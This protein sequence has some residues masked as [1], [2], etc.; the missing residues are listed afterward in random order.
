VTIS[1]TF[2]INSTP[3]P[4]K[5]LVRNELLRAGVFANSHLRSFFY[6]F[7]GHFPSL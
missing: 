3:T 4:Q 1:A 2:A 5:I 6:V 7:T